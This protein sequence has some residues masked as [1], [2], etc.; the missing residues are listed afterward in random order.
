M[1]NDFWIIPLH[2]WAIFLFLHFWLL[3]FQKLDFW[4]C[5]SKATLLL[6]TTN[7]E[8]YRVVLFYFIESSHTY[9]QMAAGYSTWTGDMTHIGSKYNYGISISKSS[10]IV[11]FSQI[12]F[13]YYVGHVTCSHIIPCCHLGI[14]VIIRWRFFSRRPFHEFDS[15]HHLLPLNSDKE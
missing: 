13:T 4:K 3:H 7:Y 6:P 14:G 8:S 12:E 1:R 10:E 2:F 5:R 15:H 9:P 11:Y